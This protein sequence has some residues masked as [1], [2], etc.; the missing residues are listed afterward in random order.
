M[1]SSGDALR[2]LI[3]V[4][5]VCV[6]LGRAIALVVRLAVR[7]DGK[8]LRWHERLVLALAA[9]GIACMAYGRFVEPRWPE[10]TRTRVT[11]SRLP[12]GHR[13]VRIVHL[14]DLH[15]APHARLEGRLPEIV[16]SLHPDLILFTGDAASSPEGVP[17]FRAC[18]AELARIAPTFAVKGNWDAWHFPKIDRFAGTGATELDGASA[19]VDVSGTNIRIVGVDVDGEPLAAQAFRTLPADGPCIVLY[20]YPYPDVVPEAAASRVDLLCAGHVHGGQVALPFYGALLTLSK[21]GKR[22]ERGLYA[23][24]GGG[25]MYVSRGIGME[26]GPAP[27]VRFCSR[28]EIALIELMP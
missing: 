10:I 1:M 12:A 15:S 26:G 24:P 23:M 11:T 27:R 5:V 18:L 13:G 25:S 21:Y 9:A 7:R 8:P 20:H 3:F 4:V 22:Y 2:A 28:P 17:V 19:S 16:A 6:V 14:S